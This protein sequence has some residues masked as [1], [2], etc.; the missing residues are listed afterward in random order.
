MRTNRARPWR[1]PPDGAA[2]L[3]AA[4]LAVAAAQAPARAQDVTARFELSQDARVLPL[5]PNRERAVALIVENKGKAEA[6]VTVR[7]LGDDPDQPLA[8]SAA[9]VKVPPG[10]KKAVSFGKPAPKPEWKRLPDT[11]KLEWAWT[12]DGKAGKASAEFRVRVE[13]P[14]EY[15]TADAKY[16]AAGKVL[17][18]TVR[19][20]EGVPDA[21]FV[22][23]PVVELVVEKEALPGLLA[24]PGEYTRKGL[25]EGED[26]VVLHAGKLSVREGMAGTVAVTVDGYERAFLFET[27]FDAK[28]LYPKVLSGPSLRLRADPYSKPVGNYAV[29]TEIDNPGSTDVQV[30]VGLKRGETSPVVTRTRKG[31]RERLNELGGAG[32]GG[33]LLFRTTVRD[34]K[35]EWD[36][37]GV[38]G[39][40]L[41]ITAELFDRAGKP[42]TRAGG[43]PVVATAAVT[44]DGTGP[45]DLEIVRA[46]KTAEPGQEVEIVARGQDNESEIQEVF[47]FLGKPTDDKKVPKDAATVPADRGKDG[48]YRAKLTMPDEG[49]EAVVSA[50][51]VNALKISEFA[52]A[53]VRLRA[54]GKDDG[55]DGDKAK[56][57]T[58]KGVVKEGVNPQPNQVVTLANAAGGPAKTTKTNAKG[59]FA[60]E[61]VEPGSYVVSAVKKISPPTKGE[62][63]VTVKAGEEPKAVEI[64]L[65]R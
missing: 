30:R 60:F 8:A 5:R 50:Q 42:V 29:Q 10:T 14:A 32:E 33:H 58:L 34:W 7:L 61:K 44:V 2:A 21:M 6:D 56:P 25:L 59:E 41:P 46:P 55:K 54:P 16:D 27:A 39:R 51:F 4:L 31:D 26:P 57:V 64:K 49:K 13:E 53:R 17:T 9:P 35:V 38:S 19:R 15:V 65:F 47:F 43:K 62:E 37:E 18:L 63:K 28:G 45:K 24:E 40:D 3:V 22:P 36:L 20:K 52:S 23:P 12:A 11:M 1:L 48:L